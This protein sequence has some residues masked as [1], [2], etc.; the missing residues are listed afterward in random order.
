ML[1]SFIIP[2]KGRLEMLRQTVK[3]ICSQEFDLEQIEVIVV[4]Q[5][6]VLAPEDLK[7]AST[8]AN[9]RIFLRPEQETIS[10]LRNYGVEHS[11]GEYIAFL[12]AD[13]DLSRNWLSAMLE[14][15]QS[16]PA[17][18]LV[19]AIQDEGDTPCPLERI[20]TCLSNA[21]TDT[22]VTF[23]PGRNLLLS[24]AT[25]DQSGGFPEH[26][27]TCEDYYFT[28]AVSQL[29]VLY[30]S[31]KASYV[32]LGEDKS[33]REMFKKEIWRGQSNLQSL[34]GRK[35]PLRELPSFLV[36]IWILVFAIV[37]LVALL[38][39]EPSLAIASALLLA[40]PISLYALRL[41]RASS[42]SISFFEITKFYVVYFP[43]RIAGTFAG[44]VKAIHP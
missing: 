4:S 21:E 5:N 28:H 41:Y 32:H 9:L 7:L 14:E 10:A 2:H 44:L 22:P 12:D 31:S 16:E 6:E 18:V 38:S 36:P 3:S 43:A 39:A 33:Y 42:N 1:V 37:C 25:F 11:Q 24:R 26:L 15:L 17:R 8:Q 30:Y 29:G 19:S 20:R 13:I 34:R 40:L 27:I 35:I 23:L